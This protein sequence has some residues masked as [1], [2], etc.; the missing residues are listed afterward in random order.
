MKKIGYRVICID[1]D[2][3]EK[4]SPLDKALAE[5]LED[6][7]GYKP[8]QERVDLLYYADFFIGISSGLSWLA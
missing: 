5:G 1:G 4:G 3:I 8:L 6:F 2:G 7:T